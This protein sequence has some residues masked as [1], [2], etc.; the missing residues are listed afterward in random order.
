MKALVLATT[1]VLTALNL[2]GQGI[3]TFTSQSLN[4]T[5]HVWGP[6]PT[7]LYLFLSGPGSSDSPAGSTPYQ[8]NGMELIGSSGRYAQYGY[9][10]TFAQLLAAPGANQTESS[11][12]PVGQTTTFRSGSSLGQIVQIDVTVPGLT[13]AY[14]AATCS[15]AIWDNSSG[16]YPTW[17]QASVAWQAGLIAAQRAAPETVPLVAG[18]G[19]YTHLSFNLAFVPEPASAALAGLGIAM[20]MVFAQRKRD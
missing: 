20:W 7:D 14:N 1:V 18:N 4:R 11:L 8:A 9:A 6:S 13:S 19:T 10:T 15:A 17:T 3:I 5:S 2:F 16:L 12:V